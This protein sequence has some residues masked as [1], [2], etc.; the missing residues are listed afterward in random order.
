MFAWLQDPK[1]HEK[2]YLPFLGCVCKRRDRGKK[3]ILAAA[4]IIL[5]G[6]LWFG[7]GL[8]ERDHCRFLLESSAY[9]ATFTLKKLVFCYF[10]KDLKK[11][12]L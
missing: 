11:Q 3:G 7:Y 4:C 8:S 10:H 5:P 9:F 6:L 1:S 12:L 2:H